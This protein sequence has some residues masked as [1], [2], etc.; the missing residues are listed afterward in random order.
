MYNE[1]VA[2]W[3]PFIEPLEDAEIGEYRPY[4]LKAKVE[5]LLVCVGREG[6]EGGEG[7]GRKE[8]REE[9][10]EGRKGGREGREGGREGY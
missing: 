2:S 4:R 5:L 8:G 7:G 10:R 9:G 6:R 3:E 1:N